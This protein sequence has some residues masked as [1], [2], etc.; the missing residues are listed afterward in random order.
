MGSRTAEDR[1]RRLETGSDREVAELG[2]GSYEPDQ[3][4]KIRAELR[5]DCRDHS[6]NDANAAPESGTGKRG[7]ERREGRHAEQSRTPGGAG[8]E[9]TNRNTRSIR[10]A[11]IHA[12]GEP[13]LIQQGEGGGI[14]IPTEI[15]TESDGTAVLRE[16]VLG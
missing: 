13:I 7:R 2:N 10:T 1:N 4:G 16:E 9:G 15:S 14:H 5:T 6:S 3:S 8:Y 12:T 11:T